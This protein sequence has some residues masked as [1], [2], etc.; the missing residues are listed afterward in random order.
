MDYHIKTVKAL[1][2][3]CDHPTKDLFD[4]ADNQ[5]RGKKN[6]INPNLMKYTYL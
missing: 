2:A 6:K 3:P 5:K 1:P 4:Q